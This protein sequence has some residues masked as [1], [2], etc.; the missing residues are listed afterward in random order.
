MC[1]LPSTCSREG[2][3][4]EQR[5]I[6]IPVHKKGSVYNTANYRGIA[7]LDVFSKIN[8]YIL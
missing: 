3:F 1:Y 6:T 5:T 4:P 7:L 2:E 8:I